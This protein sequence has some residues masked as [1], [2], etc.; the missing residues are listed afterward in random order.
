MAPDRIAE[1]TAAV[2]PEDL[3]HL[4]YR[5]ALTAMCELAAKS[6][7]VNIDTVTRRLN[8]V[9]LNGQPIL[10]QTGGNQ[11]LAEALTGVN[12]DEVDY[13]APLVKASRQ[14]R[15][16]R[17]LVDAAQTEIGALGSEPADIESYKSKFEERLVAL[18]RATGESN[19]HSIDSVLPKLQ[20]RIERYISDPNAI[21]GMEVGWTIFDDYLD[22]LQP[23]NVSIVYAPTSRYKSLFVQNIGWALATFGHAGLWF[24]TEMPRVQV[25]ERVLQLESG[26]NLRA[27]RKNG[28]IAGFRGQIAS[29]TRAV[30][31]LPIYIDDRG[32]LDTA[33]I[34]AETARQKRWN[35]TE[36]VIVDLIDKVTTS[37]FSSEPVANMS[38]VMDKMKTTA[39][40]T[41]THVMLTSHI[42]KGDRSLA[43]RVELEVEDMKGSSSKYQDV[44]C[45][46]SLMPVGED[47]NGDYYG[48]T[49]EEIAARVA[50]YQHVDVMVT[51]TKNRHGETGRILFDLDMSQGGRFTPAAQLPALTAPLMQAVA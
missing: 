13:W 27:L 19:V 44:D 11:F 10:D 15:E 20:A 1:F 47:E 40:Q 5:W 23:G 12:A 49:R 6:Q 21:T 4:P 32:S 39:I 51:I 22:G 31:Q 26:L 42:A 35:N 14:K 50:Q 18:T 48:L 29:A 28:S 17:A 34:H 3:F 24:T 9:K 25:T 43:K 38:V 45:A 36:L 46:I 30:G 41:D 7:P 16:L 37:R 2:G 33:Y 8:S